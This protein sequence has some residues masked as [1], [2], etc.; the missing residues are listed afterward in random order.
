M[1]DRGRFIGGTGRG[2]NIWD[3]ANN[4]DTYK[5]PRVFSRAIVA[6]NMR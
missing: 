1:D 2:Y 6:P 4:V 3:I 5:S